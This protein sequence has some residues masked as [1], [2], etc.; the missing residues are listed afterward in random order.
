MSRDTS[1]PSFVLSKDNA[2]H[3][4]IPQTQGSL[5]D[6]GYTYNQ[7]GFT[8]NQ[9]GWKYGGIQNVNEDI[10]PTISLAQ[11]IFPSLQIPKTQASLT[12]QGY[13]YNQAG[14]TYNQAG[15]F[16]GGLNNSDQ[17]IVPILSL[18]QLELPRNILFSDL[19]TQGTITPAASKN[20]PGFLMYVNLS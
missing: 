11:N 19:A 8:Y 9:A 12:D 10:V 16:Y 4:Q 15:W 14:F 20:G 13:T 1:I 3:L 18:A 6:Q 7:A 5:V 17:D 2:I